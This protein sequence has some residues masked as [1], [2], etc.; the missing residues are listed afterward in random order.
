M[1]NCYVRLSDLKAAIQGAGSGT[2]N[3]AVLLRASESASRWVDEHCDR[4]F[5]SLWAQTVLLPDH[6]RPRHVPDTELWLPRDVISITTLKVDDDGD[7]VF[8]ETLTVDTDYWLW[9]YNRLANEPV[10]RIDLNPE[11][12][13]SA[14]P[15]APR[16]VQ[17]VGKTGYSEET[18]AAGTI[19]E[20]LDSSETGVDM[21]AGHDVAAGDTIFIDSEQM[22]VTAVAT[23]TA[24]VTR[25]VNGTTAATHD[26]GAAI[27]RRRYPRDVEQAVTMQAA[28]IVREA[29]TGYGGAVGSGDLGGYQFRSMYPAIRDLLA[30]YVMPRIS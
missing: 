6:A 14:W 19:A 28:R 22:D 17:L 4:H 2:S 9:P 3:D 25:G 24:T 26:S 1:P 15:S 11:G 5:Y 8:E 30:P 20:A 29:Q 10:Q 18:Q 7:G 23:N 12:S 13:R 21:T 16:R 27:T